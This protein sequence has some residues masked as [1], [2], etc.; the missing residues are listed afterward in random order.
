MS[1]KAL[2]IGSGVAG[3]A[4]GLFLRRIGWEA[5]IYEA[6]AEPDDYAGAFLNVATNGLA[7]LDTL[8]VRDRLLTDAF[9]CPKMIMWSGRGKQLGVVP[10]GPAGDPARGSAVVQRG[11][12][13]RVLREEARARE[14]PIHFGKRLTTITQ[15]EGGVRATFEDG[16][17]AEG[18]ILIGADGIGSPT[19]RY[20]DPD[21]PAPAYAGIVAVGGYA[22]TPAAPPLADTQHM[23]FG[24]RSFFGHLTRADGTV[25]WFANITRPEP[26]RGELRATTTDQW[27]ELLS[28]LHRDDPSP[29]PEI[30]AANTDEVRGYPVHDLHH[31]TRWHRGSVVALGDAVHATSPSAGQGT[32][33][34]L[35]DTI[36]LA[37]ALRDEAT[38]DGAFAAFQ[39]IRQPRVEAVVGYAQE[40]TKR[41]TISR[42]PIAVRMRDAMLPIFLCRAATDTRLNWLYDHHIPWTSEPEL[43]RTS[44]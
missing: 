19:R 32:S 38:L 16:T 22:R 37:R 6:G 36:V 5:E 24:R 42:N 4:M 11:W 39:R 30:L 44:G 40:I 31:V 2:V 7:V 41:K 12:L 26:A 21:S 43:H 35:E 23:I 3:P 28:G 25:Y 1:P 14:V 27:L 20:L 18:E 13:H 29:V 17:T 8:D 15:L 10:N 33:L 34:A 9:H